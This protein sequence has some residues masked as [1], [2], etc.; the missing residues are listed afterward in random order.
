MSYLICLYVYYHGNNLSAF[1]FDP[2]KAPM[3]E[4]NTGLKRD[5]AKD[6]EGLL[7]DDVVK[8]MVASEKSSAAVNDYEDIFRKAL[9][10][11]QGSTR[12][13]LNS[14]LNVSAGSVDSMDFDIGDDDGNIGMDFFD[15]MN[16][17]GTYK[18]DTYSGWP[19]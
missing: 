19:F 1:G 17:L 11:A 4:L 18:R 10:E 14:S 7:P 2:G 8:S 13:M 5:S 15:E 16:G 9:A 6:F 12:A 3:E